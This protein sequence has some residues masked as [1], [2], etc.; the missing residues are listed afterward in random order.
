MEDKDDPLSL[1]AALK[2]GHYL[3]VIGDLINAL[4]FQAESGTARAQMGDTLRVEP[5]AN[6]EITSRFRSPSANNH[7]DP[8][9]VHHVDLIAGEVS[10][11]KVPGTSDYKKTEVTSSTRVIA[12]FTDWQIGA[13]GYSL[14]TYRV[15]NPSTSMY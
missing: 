8:V 4:E 3:P 14:I 1:V 9:A 15:E 11:L 2:A 13:D 5:G 7:G 12:R 6:V 10:G